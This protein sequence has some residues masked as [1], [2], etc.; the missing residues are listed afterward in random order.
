M[1]LVR[2]KRL[3][4]KTKSYILYKYNKLHL[5]YEKGLVI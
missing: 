2:F 5:F 3:Y 4:L 1:I